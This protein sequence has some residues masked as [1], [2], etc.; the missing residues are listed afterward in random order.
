V[1]A[2]EIYRLDSRDRPHRASAPATIREG[3]FRDF[4]AAT[5]PWAP[6][7]IPRHI[8]IDLQRVAVICRPRACSSAAVSV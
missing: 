2:E 1:P 3:G 4:S 8:G 7:T 5:L 6:C